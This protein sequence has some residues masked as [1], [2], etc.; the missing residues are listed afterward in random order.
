MTFEPFK[1]GALERIYSTRANDLQ[2]V[3]ESEEYKK[4]RDCYIELFLEKKER[5]TKKL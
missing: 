2:R 3:Q 5:I 4:F 1:N